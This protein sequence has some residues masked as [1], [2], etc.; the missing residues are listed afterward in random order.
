MQKQ[1]M[2]RRKQQELMQQQQ[3]QNND[4]DKT[5]G[6]EESKTG[7]SQSSDVQ[8]DK[9]NNK[10][11]NPRNIGKSIHKIGFTFHRSIPIF[12]DRLSTDVF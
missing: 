10:S 8:M 3:L 7:E 12:V 11:N 2:L 9:S 5:A 1:E 6:V 4:H